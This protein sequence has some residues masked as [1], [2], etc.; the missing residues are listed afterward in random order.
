MFSVGIEE[1]LFFATG[2]WGWGEGGFVSA[3]L[4]SKTDPSLT[5]CFAGASAAKHKSKIAP[6]AKKENRAKRQTTDSVSD[7]V[8]RDDP[9]GIGTSCGTCIS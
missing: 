5:C 7:S 2:A 4:N 9:K 3:V 6:A 8:L 1:C